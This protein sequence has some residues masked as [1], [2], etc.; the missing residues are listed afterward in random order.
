MINRILLLVTGTLSIV[1]CSIHQ[2]ISSGTEIYDR[3]TL[4]DSR[5]SDFYMYDESLPD[6]PG[7]LLRRE[8]LDKRQVLEKAAKNVRILYTS[9]DG[10]TGTDLVAVSGVLYLPHGTPPE[11]GWPLMAWTHGTVG[12]AD[13]CAPSWAGRHEQDM[14]YLNQFL[15]NGYAIV[16]S[17]YQGLGTKG[18]HPYLAT[19]PAAYSNLDIIRAVRSAGISVSEE[20]VVFGQSQGAGAAIATAGFAPEYA[21]EIKLVGVVATG[22]P[23]FTPAALEA[24]DRVRKPD[25]PDPMLGY[26]F[27]AM[28]LAQQADPG[29]DMREYIS[30]EAWPIAARVDDTCYAEI[31]ALV[32]AQQ[33]TRNSSFTQTPRIALR[34]AFALM[35]YPDLNLQAPVF[36]GTGGQDKDTPPR[37]QA[38]LVKNLCKAGS[39][40][41]SKLYS[42]LD[43]RGVVLPSLK[44]SEPFVRAA[45]AGEK[46]EGNCADLPFGKK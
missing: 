9:T 16:A 38:A 12:I 23:Y 4:G 24:L 2:G 31:K 45:F 6:K 10:L 42:D 15:A 29:F 44:D 8:K 41:Y 36:F 27:L 14:I 11:G 7:V 21:P 13:V 3:A 33:L 25:L 37:M 1:S 35:S 20:V 40:V 18:I 39:T 5:L 22:A 28:T 32:T 30:G 26:T 46:I 17:D 43:H 34:S 19:R